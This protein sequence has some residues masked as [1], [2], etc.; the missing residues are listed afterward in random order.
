MKF[1]YLSKMFKDKLKDIDNISLTSDIWTDIQMKS[2]IGL[3]IH[4][5]EGT[6]FKSGTIGVHELSKS[7][8]SE[9]IGESFKT[10]LSQW[11]I[12]HNQI[13]AI[14]T[15]NAANMKKAASDIFGTE[16]YI[17]CFAHTVNLNVNNAPR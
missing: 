15:D 7:H 2:Y 17:P 9:H 11:E 8:T 13:I 5:L 1:D 14:V 10:V 12:N 16:K 3:T 6:K 4:Y